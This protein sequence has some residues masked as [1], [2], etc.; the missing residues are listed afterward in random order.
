MNYY[1]FMTKN[2]K[3]EDAVRS[4]N[5]PENITEC[6]LQ[7]G[8]RGFVN[9]VAAEGGESFVMFTNADDFVAGSY[10]DGGAASFETGTLRVWTHLV[11]QTTWIYDIGAFTGAF[12]LAAVATNPN[13]YVMAFEPSFIT[14]SRLLV[15]IHANAFNDRIAPM[16]FGLGDAIDEMELRHP[17]GV[18]VM[19]SGESFLETHISDPWF[20]EKVPVITLDELIGNQAA[21]RKQIVIDATFN[22][23]ELLK[24]DVEGFESNVLK[25]MQN[26]IREHRPTAIVEILDAKEVDEILE[27]FGPGYEVLHINEET[28]SLSSNPS[29]TN[30]LFIHEDRGALLTGYAY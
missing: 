12:G 27:L 16:R 8:Y 28:G 5:H 7:I 29:G 13:C 20:V 18:Y 26:L 2:L 22:G 3:A 1:E 10:Y 15:N 14:Y 19:A 24:I 9:C 23:V 17:S 21:Y 25:G 30:K 4:G 11:K 6:N